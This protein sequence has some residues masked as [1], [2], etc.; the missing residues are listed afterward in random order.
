MLFVHTLPT[1][2]AQVRSSYSTIVR[3]VPKYSKIHSLSHTH[4]HHSFQYRIDAISSGTIRNASLSHTGTSSAFS[5]QVFATTESVPGGYGVTFSRNLAVC[6]RNA[7][8]L[9]ILNEPSICFCQF[10]L[11]YH[12]YRSQ[13]YKASSSNRL[14]SSAHSLVP[15]STSINILQTSR[16]RLTCNIV[17]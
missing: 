15:A 11:C 7:S 9:P 6:F 5:A 16:W 3:R 12:V 2:F 14:M 10:F 1:Y 17:E 4:T 8:I 13:D